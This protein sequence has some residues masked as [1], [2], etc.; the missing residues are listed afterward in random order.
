LIKNKSK[1]AKKL[2][3]PQVAQTTPRVGQFGPP[4]GVV[5]AKELNRSTDAR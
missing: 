1:G 2:R 3:T 4:G 5:W